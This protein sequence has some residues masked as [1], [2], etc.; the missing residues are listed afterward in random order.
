MKQNKPKYINKRAVSEACFRD[1]CDNVNRRWNGYS[2]CDTDFDAGPVEEDAKGGAVDGD[3]QAGGRF[4]IAFYRNLAY[5][6][7]A[8]A[9]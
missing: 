5:R 8:A 2:L 3:F 6:G 9:V 4:Y 1:G 7:T